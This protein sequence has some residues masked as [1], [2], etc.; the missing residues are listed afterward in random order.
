[1]SDERLSPIEIDRAREVLVKVTRA[2]S[3][4]SVEVQQIGIQAFVEYSPTTGKITR[5]VL[6]MIPDAATRSFM[7]ALQGFLDHEVAHILF[8][9]FEYS[10][11]RNAEVRK[12]RKM[13]ALTQILEDVRIEKRMSDKYAGSICNLSDVRTFVLDQLIHPDVKKLIRAGASDD[14]IASRVL[15]AALRALGGQR[16][17][18]QYMES[19]GLW[20]HYGL[21]GVKLRAFESRIQNLASTKD[22]FELA[23]ELEN[24]IW[25]KKPKPDKG[26]DKPDP[27]ESEE[28]GEAGESS[29]DPGEDGNE[30]EDQGEAEDKGE[31][32]SE[33]E[34][35]DEG[36][37]EAEGKDEAES[38]DEDEAE[39]DEP[40]ESGESDED[41]NKDDSGESDKSGESD[42]DEDED[43]DGSG[44]PDE[45]DEVD[46]SGEV[47]AESEI[48][49][50]AVGSE[51]TDEDGVMIDE[52]AIRNFDDEMS[53]AISASALKAISTG[54]SY[55]PFSTMAD[56]VGPLIG[57]ADVDT[58]EM[59]KK[60]HDNAI[61]HS[62]ILQS[63]IQ[64]VFRAKSAAR[65]EPG[66]RRGK[67]NPSALHRVVQGDDR[68]FRKKA[69]TTTKSIAVELVVDMSGS[70]SM[71]GKI[72]SACLSAYI[73]ANILDNLGIAHEIVGFSTLTNFVKDNT[74]GLGSK[75]DAIYETYGSQR[76][77]DP[78]LLNKFG[79]VVPT[80]LYVLKDFNQRFGEQQRR[81]LTSIA[82]NRVF[83]RVASCNVDG[84]SLVQSYKRLT[85]RREARKIMIVMSDG[86]PSADASDALLEMNLKRT[87]GEIEKAGVEVYALG[88]M[89]RAVKQFYKNYEVAMAAGQIPTSILNLLK[90][91]LN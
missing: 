29:E 89:D 26:P 30:A 3:D 31:D 11:T 81:Q 28:S 7:R 57:Y 88:L 27:E 35:E 79:R 47:E 53:E 56:Y 46:E 66:L 60:I 14:Q 58:S 84:E 61:K 20:K 63:E 62:A 71:D 1:M 74:P 50:N 78:G 34:S 23:T 70:M 42:E 52:D 68:V 19:H 18:T 65:W 43:E 55:T 37:A 24:V 73:F 15:P 76:R 51:I 48:E 22:V 4:S 8:T 10:A 72:Y 38:E 9:D 39:G 83:S 36:K 77:A 85:T 33:S 13:F 44:E 16:E 49:G 91:M 32:E 59:E 67:L 12:N 17:M 5:V 45:S 90:K 40:G 82:D 41:E 75:V 54:G 2:L 69:V 86:N 6:P 87:V 64:R 25:P 21:M 80:A